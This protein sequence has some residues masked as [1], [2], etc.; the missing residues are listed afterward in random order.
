M[1]VPH[2]GVKR[3]ARRHGG[4]PPDGIEHPRTMDRPRGGLP[5]RREHSLGVSAHYAYVEGGWAGARC[6]QTA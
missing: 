6:S 5:G 4:A 3:L 2:S 1:H